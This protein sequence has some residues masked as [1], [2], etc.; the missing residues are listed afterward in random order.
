MC[1]MWVDF[2]LI[3]KKR[4]HVSWLHKKTLY[5]RT[6]KEMRWDSKH[7]LESKQWTW[8]MSA[9]GNSKRYWE[10]IGFPT[11][12]E[13]TVNSV[14]GVFR[15]RICKLRWLWLLI[16]G[17]QRNHRITTTHLEQDILECEVKWALESIT[18][19]KASGND[20]IPVELFQT[21]KDDAVKVLHAICQQVCKTQQWP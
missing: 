13:S 5:Q 15:D 7:S 19:N 8:R 11:N 21:L 12:C 18:T 20:R 14:F 3:L 9:W 10:N 1:L 4:S 6:W 16:G 17:H 2:I